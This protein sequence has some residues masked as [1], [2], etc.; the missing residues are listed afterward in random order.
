MEAD[1]QRVIAVLGAGDFDIAI[2]GEFLAHGEE[3]LPERVDGLAEAGGEETAFE[4]GGAEN[5][6]LGEGHALGPRGYPEHLLG[7]DGL[8]DG[9]EVLPEV[10]DFL[11][12]FEAD[13]GEGGG[14][15]AV[16]AGILGGAGLALGS[17]RSGRPG[18]VSG[19]RGH[20]GGDAFWRYEVRSA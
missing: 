10:G 6:L 18:G 15:E 14:G 11:E 1:A 2:A 13:D 16:L 3:R 8:V 12:V 9:Q 5:G 4:A 17:A 7:I 19:P 20:P